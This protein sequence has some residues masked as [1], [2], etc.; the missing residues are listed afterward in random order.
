MDLKV[1]FVII[2][3]I[4]GIGS[5]LMGIFVNLFVVLVLVMGLNVF[6][7]FVVVGVMGIFW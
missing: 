6:F 3:L 4:V 7:V 2:C 1:V 5:I